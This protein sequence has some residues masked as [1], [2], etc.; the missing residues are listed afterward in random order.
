MLPARR[1]LFVFASTWKSELCHH[2]GTLNSKSARAWNSLGALPKL[3][4]S[5][6]ALGCHLP[7]PSAAKHADELLVL[8][9]VRGISCGGGSYLICTMIA[10]PSYVFF[11]S[12]WT[13][14]YPY[15]KEDLLGLLS[16]L[17]EKSCFV[18]VV[19]T[20]HCMCDFSLVLLHRKVLSS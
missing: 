8:L 19:F 17:Q 13:I 14:R 4:T 10:A 3:G 11:F 18:V 12:W 6:T 2:N 1:V 7:N 5:S 16:V 15:F 9:S 20:L